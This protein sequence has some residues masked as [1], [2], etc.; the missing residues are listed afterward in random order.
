[1]T[2]SPVNSA[3]GI[4]G[5]PCS[6]T[7]GSMSN[8]A[9]TQAM[10]RYK[11]RRAKC[12]PGQTLRITNPV[13][14]RRGS[15]ELYLLPSSSTENSL[16]R[17]KHCRV[18]FPVLEEPVRIEGLWVGIYVRITADCPDV[19]YHGCPCRDEVPP[20]YIVLCNS[21][22]ETDGK[23]WSPPEDFLYNGIDIRKIFPIREIWKAVFSHN[24]V[25]F[26][27]RLLQHFGVPGHCQEERLQRQPC[28]EA[29]SVK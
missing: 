3:S 18:D 7:V 20:V 23:G 22:W 24:A 17:V 19:L 15:Y 12:W 28:L 8:T 27:L 26:I 29:T 4:S 16:F 11:V 14:P 21:F 2:E 5:F 9:D 10:T 25:Q 13:I 1:M 6:F